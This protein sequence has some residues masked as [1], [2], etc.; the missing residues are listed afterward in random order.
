MGLL[1]ARLGLDQAEG[2]DLRQFVDAPL[3][4]NRLAAYS[5]IELHLTCGTGGGTR[6]G[7]VEAV[8]GRRGLQQ[9]LK[10]RLRIAEDAR[11]APVRPSRHLPRLVLDEDAFFKS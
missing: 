4:A 1:G 7:A 5:L 9:L 3:G 11:V 8:H 10:L 2:S 6:P